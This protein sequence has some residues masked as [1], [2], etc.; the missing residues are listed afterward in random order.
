MVGAGI[1]FVLTENFLLLLI[2]A[3]VGVI[4]PSGNEVGPFL[5]IEQA[6]LSQVIPANRRTGVFAWYS[7]VGSFATATGSLAGGLAVH[8]LQLIESPAASYRT[9]IVGYAVL[10]LLLAGLFLKLSSAVEVPPAARNTA[11][12]RL[13]LGKSRHVVFRLSSLFALDA[14]GGDELT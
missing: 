3:T 12:Q 6:A 1:T 2:A 10:G 13:G 7:L 5:S 14:F 4:S 9:V 11:P 8:G